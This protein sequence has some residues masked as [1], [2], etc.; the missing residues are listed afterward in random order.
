MPRVG[1]CYYLLSYSDWRLFFACIRFLGSELRYV[2][3][4]MVVTY[5]SYRCE[6]TCAL[7]WNLKSSENWFFNVLVVLT[8]GITLFYDCNG[9]HVFIFLSNTVIFNHFFLKHYTI[10]IALYFLLYISF[11]YAFILPCSAITFSS[12]SFEWKSCLQLQML[13]W[14]CLPT[15]SGTKGMNHTLKN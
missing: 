4:D 10:Y 5:S 13:Q 14:S 15:W 8:L 6:C 7:F 2:K 3:C 1:I 11:H 12:C 9:V